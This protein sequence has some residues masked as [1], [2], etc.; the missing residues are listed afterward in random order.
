MSCQAGTT[1]SMPITETSSAVS[2]AHPAIAF[3]LDD[4]DGAG[5]GDAEI[6][7]ADRHRRA[8]K[9]LPQVRPG[10]GRK[11]AGFV[12]QAFGVLEPA[13]EQLVD[14]RAVLVDRRHEDVRRPLAG[15]LDDQLG[16]VRLDRLDAGPGQPSLR[17]ISSVV[18]DLILTTSFAPWPVTIPAMIWLAS[19][20]S[21][22]QCTRPPA[23]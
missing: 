23:G 19:P 22:A 21:R 1:F 13:A 15:K 17:P 4:A 14:L 11:R 20:A 18:S 10:R 7:P 2:Q 12:G 16:Q 5:F 8:Q 9:L 3:R 6:R